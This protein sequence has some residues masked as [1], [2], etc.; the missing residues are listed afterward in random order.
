MTHNHINQNHMAT[1]IKAIIFDMDGILLDTESICNK[2]WEIAG[3]EWNLNNPLE[4][5]TRCRGT[6]KN[7]TKSILKEFY[8]TNFDA[9]SYLARTSEL[10]HQIEK[11]SGIPLMPYAKETLEYLAKKYRLALA[12]ST[13]EIVVR[14]HLNAQ[15]L[16]S[17]FE[18][19]TTGDMV[20]HSKPDPE[21]Y[22]LAC[23]SL[24]LNPSECLSI[25][26]SPNG[27]KSAVSAG[28]KTIMIPDTIQPTPEI[29]A[30]AWQIY[31]NL[32]EMCTIL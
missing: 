3:K 32:K 4:A 12:S 19:I 24:K 15:N 30:L 17:Y 25:E 8:G 5:I 11:T 2:T 1:D 10:F 27:I 9:D 28:I 31:P 13:R 22:K 6:N 23:N 7:D 14:E 29:K 16:L 26:D 21:I 20:K 18:T